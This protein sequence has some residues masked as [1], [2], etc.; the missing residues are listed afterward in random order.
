MAPLR[1]VE[2]SDPLVLGGGGAAAL[3]ATHPLWLKALGVQ[4][5]KEATDDKTEVEQYFNTVGFERWNKIYSESDEV[6]K[7]REGGG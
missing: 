2:L 1:G 4:K 6:N 5:P 3:V 7:V